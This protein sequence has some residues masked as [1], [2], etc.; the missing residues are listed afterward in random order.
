MCIINPSTAN[1]NSHHVVNI[2][3][4]IFK[5]NTKLL[6]YPQVADDSTLYGCCVLVEEVVQK[7]SGL[8]SMISDERPFCSSLNRLVITTPRCYCI[9]SRL[10]FFE[11]HFGILKRCANWVSSDLICQFKN[12]ACFLLK[13]PFPFSVPFLLFICINPVILL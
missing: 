10:P 8:I 1:E 4:L 12:L 9:I 11:L 3:F 5:F 7:P 6:V 2:T 13:W